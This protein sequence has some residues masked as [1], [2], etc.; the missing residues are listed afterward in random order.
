MPMDVTRGRLSTEGVHSFMPM[1]VI[2]GRLSRKASKLGCLWTSHKEKHDLAWFP[3]LN[4]ADMVSVLKQN[5]CFKTRR[6]IA[7]FDASLQTIQQIPNFH[8][9]S[10]LVS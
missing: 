6:L 8:F 2:R 4:S 9:P 5:F 1:D 3:F 10:T 7:V